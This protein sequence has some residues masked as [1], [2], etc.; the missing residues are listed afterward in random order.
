MKKPAWAR[1]DL[2][3]KVLVLEGLQDPG[4]LGTILRTA[5]ALGGFSVITLG[6][7]VSFYN[8]KVVRA[9]AGYLFLVPFLQGV[10]VSDLRELGY[11]IWFSSP[12]DG[13]KVREADFHSPLAVVFGSEGQGLAGGDGESGKRITIPMLSGRDSLN[14]AVAASLVMYEINRGAPE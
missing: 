10:T 12:S 7:T 2:T 5:S 4:N 13:T 8:R 6:N 14:V 1:K 11:Q 3:D 9:S